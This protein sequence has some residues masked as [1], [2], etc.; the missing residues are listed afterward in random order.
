MIAQC[1]DDDSFCLNNSHFQFSMKSFSENL[2]EWNFSVSA[3]EKWAHSSKI[4][5][6]NKTQ[7]A[8]RIENA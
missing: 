2:K 1:H 3:K 5:A 8:D 4:D 7:F 6:K